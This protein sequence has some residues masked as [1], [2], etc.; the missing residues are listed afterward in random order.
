MRY[1]HCHYQDCTNDNISP[2]DEMGLC[3][4]HFAM[5]LE[6]YQQLD[7]RLATQVQAER[8]HWMLNK[9]GVIPT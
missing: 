9:F 4:H 2:F 6:A 1:P 5:A 8:T 7:W 3:L